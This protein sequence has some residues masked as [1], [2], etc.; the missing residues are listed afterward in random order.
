[1]TQTTQSA[2]LSLLRF[3][4]LMFHV[5]YSTKFKLNCVLQLSIDVVSALLCLMFISTHNL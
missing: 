4:T 2:E 5:L 3:Q 1:M